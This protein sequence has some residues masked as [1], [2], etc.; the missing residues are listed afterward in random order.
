MEIWKI[1]VC[2]IVLLT[3]I[4]II[5]KSSNNEDYANI[6]EVYNDPYYYFSWV[7]RYPY[8]FWNYL[9]G[10]WWDYPAYYPAYP[11]SYYPVYYNDRNY[12][13]HNRVRPRH[14]H[15]GNPQRGGII[16]PSHHNHH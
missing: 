8:K 7:W 10:W 15:R 4:H 1:V 16:P 14:P 2:I 11:T 9:T 6:Y 13:R 3:I 12:Y 5:S